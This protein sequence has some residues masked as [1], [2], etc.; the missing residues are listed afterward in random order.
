MNEYTVEECLRL[1]A[2]YAESGNYDGSICYSLMGILG[3][4]LQSQREDQQ[5]SALVALAVAAEGFFEYPS[6]DGFQNC[7]NALDAIRS[8]K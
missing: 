5:K 3:S 7:L 2:R 6:D 8:Q 1:S 4:M